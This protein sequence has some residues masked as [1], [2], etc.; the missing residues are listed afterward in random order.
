LYAGILN[1]NQKMAV[2]SN[3]DA[4]MSRTLESNTDGLRIVTYNCRSVK[5][6]IGSVKQLCRNSDI[7]ILQEHWLLPD[8][9]GF[10]SCI[11]T[12][13]VAFGSSAVNTQSNLLTGRPYGGTAILCRRALAANVKLETLD[14]V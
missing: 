12:D 10:L 6:S 4:A 5:S 7:V 2:S 14:L 13:F 8:D 3:V 11:D 1:Q 9:I